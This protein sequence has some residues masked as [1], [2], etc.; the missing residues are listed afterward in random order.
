MI[1]LGLTSSSVS[2][3]SMGDATEMETRR[4]TTERDLRVFM[5][6]EEVNDWP[7]SERQ[8]KKTEEDEGTKNE[9]RS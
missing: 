6:Q 3:T 8:V 2:T 4:R 9:E 5:V 1:S 7:G